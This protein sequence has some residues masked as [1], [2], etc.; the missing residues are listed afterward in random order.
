MK[1]TRL[2]LSELSPAQRE[3]WRDIHT[4]D[5]QI[6]SP[7]FHPE[8]SLAVGEIRTDAEVGVLEHAGE[9]VGFFPY[10]RVRRNLGRPI[11]LTLS[12]LHGLIVR[13]DVEVN[14]L[15]LIRGCGLRAWHFDHLPAQQQAFAGHHLCEA[16]SPYLDLSAGFEAYRRERAAAGSALLGQVLRK[17]RKIQREVGPLRFEPH[18]SDPEVFQALLR[19]KAEQHHRTRMFDIFQLPWVV[20]LLERIRNTEVEGFAGRLSALY[21]GDR[22]AAVH[23][24]MATPRVWHWWFPTYDRE[25]EKYSPGL[26]LLVELA[27]A[28]AAAGVQR[29]DLGKGPEQYKQSFKSAALPLAEGSVDPRL[30]ARVLWGGFYRARAFARSPQMRGPMQLPVMI[31][32]RMRAWM[33]LG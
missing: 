1:V 9:T 25:L 24:G 30:G 32:R 4:A 22:L 2:R 33:L 3:I 8:F 6:D 28:A 10:H 27:T 21:V 17:S 19:W 16:D 13:P 5:P 12:D 11:G 18:T 7:Y 14:A 20:S 31:Y 29:I 15:E 23:L 26:I